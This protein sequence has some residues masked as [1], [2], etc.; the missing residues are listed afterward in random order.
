MC[1]GLRDYDVWKL[2]CCSLSSQ[3]FSSQKLSWEGVLREG[4][5][6]FFNR[7][8]ATVY[9]QRYQVFF[10]QPWEKWSDNI[11]SKH[12]RGKFCGL[13]CFFNLHKYLSFSTPSKIR[14]TKILLSKSWDYGPVKVNQI[15]VAVFR[16]GFGNLL[17]LS[18]PGGADYAHHITTYILAPPEFQIFLRTW[19]CS[20]VLG[21]PENPRNLGVQKKGQKER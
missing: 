2:T 10:T 3:L 6:P 11:N 12:K 19:I 1:I 9:M 16:F 17:T 5:R 21:V 7:H 4:S 18:Q 15:Y 14:N 13:A 8:G 20:G